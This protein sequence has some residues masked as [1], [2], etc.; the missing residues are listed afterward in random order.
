MNLIEVSMAALVLSIAILGLVSA[1]TSTVIVDAVT[2]ENNVALHAARQV[3]EQVKSD[4]FSSLKGKAN[5]I[6]PPVSDPESTAADISAGEIDQNTA[7]Y[8]NYANQADYLGSGYT[9]ES[10]Q[11]FST[12]GDYG[13][14]Q[15]STDWYGNDLPL[16]GEDYTGDSILI[17]AKGNFEVSDPQ[18]GALQPWEMQWPGMTPPAV[19]SVLIAHARD[20]N[21]QVVD[22]VLDI[23][24][25]VRW[26]GQKGNQTKILRSQ[27]ADWGE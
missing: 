8:C 26:H 6:M 9:Y 5:Y 7:P 12:Y 11:A 23:V 17:D 3:I 15:V 21:G 20:A 10:D 13:Y 25:M 24:V 1:I 18:M 2:Q 22:D 27:I 16:A 14:V 4:G 19:G